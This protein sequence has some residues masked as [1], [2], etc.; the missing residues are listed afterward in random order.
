[1][2]TPPAVRALYVHVPFCRS[3]CGYCDF[4]SELFRP[5]A[6][7]PFVNA[8]ATESAAYVAC[9][10]PV[11]QTIFIGGGTPSMLPVDA[12]GRLLRICTAAAGDAATEFTVEA[13]P[14]TIDAEKAAVLAAAGVNRVSMGAQ[15]FNP[16]ELAALERTHRP[17]QVA[18]TIRICRAAGVP[19]ISLD[20]IF[21]IPGQDL[22]SW[23]A[24][25]DQAISL[26][27]EHIS[28]YGLTYEP[29]TR[30]HAR[31]AAGQ[32][33]PVD[34]DLE[35]DMYEAAIDRLAA[36]GYAQYEISNFAR[37]GQQCRHNLVYW[38]NEPYIGI[39]PSAAG[40]LGGER[41]KNVADLAEYV[42]RV[43]GGADPRAEMERLPEER[44]A[45]ETVMLALRTTAGLSRARFA[46]RF[47]QDP[48]AYFAQ[49]D[50]G[51]AISENVAD[52]LLEVTTDAIRLTRR[53]LL[54]ANKVMADFL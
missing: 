4:Y 12:L 14:A 3:R 46:E 50:G 39:G 21:A 54:L 23:L 42:R 25:L 45:G 47:G 9:W 15:S 13:N 40:Y 53:G 16:A 24:S 32:V 52:G 35:A 38:A 27:P 28:C 31:V 18:E 44:S 41:Y 34:Q 11:L 36:A 22:H 48:V 7:E 17:E 1:M 37:P 19:A 5:A 26:G 43:E 30:L 6:V 20:L 29:G 51:S 8:L 10:K 2:T 33:T 49:R